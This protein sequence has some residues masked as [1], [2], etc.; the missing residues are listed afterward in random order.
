[1]CSLLLSTT[2]CLVYS[3]RTPL[4]LWLSWI[5]FLQSFFMGTEQQQWW[6]KLSIMT[7]S[8]PYSAVSFFISWIKRRLWACNVTLVD[9]ERLMSG[10]HWY[11]DQHK[12]IYYNL[13]Y[14]CLDKSPAGTVKGLHQNVTE[15]WNGSLKLCVCICSHVCL[16][17][18]FMF[19]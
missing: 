16:C 5:R 3:S 10:F 19:L 14:L 17:P 6:R 11:M 4:S 2:S 12:S 18:F 8:V 15:I 13:H 7:T 1:M 9:C